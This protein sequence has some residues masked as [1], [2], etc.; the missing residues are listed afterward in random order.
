MGAVKKV[1]KRKTTKRRRRSVSRGISRR[2]RPRGVGTNGDEKKG[3]TVPMWAA[4]VALI[5]TAV[6][7]G[8]GRR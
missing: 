3:A 8:R 2:R 1:A 6:I 5:G 7:L 4:M